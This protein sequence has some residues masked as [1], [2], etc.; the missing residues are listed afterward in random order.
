MWLII[1]DLQDVYNFV[2]IKS[3]NPFSRDFGKMSILFANL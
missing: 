3:V 1:N 2:F